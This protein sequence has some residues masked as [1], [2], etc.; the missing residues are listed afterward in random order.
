MQM[1]EQHRIQQ[2]YATNPDGSPNFAP[3]HSSNALS[4]SG[5]MGGG[6][7]AAALKESGVLELLS[8]P[9]GRAAIGAL[10]GRV[11]SARQKT[12]SDIQ[13]WD[14]EKKSV[15]F[16]S[17]IEH[18]LITDMTTTAT[19]PLASIM[20]FI[21]LPDHDIE[22]LMSFMLVAADK[23]GKL[24]REF[25]ASTAAGGGLGPTDQG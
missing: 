22:Q 21:A 2:Q 7:S 23:D 12:E 16:N 9:D 6:A 8:K 10:A 1:R 13:S 4:T 14:D 18:P 24:M 25:N 19:D 3:N 17:F 20:K 11:Q 15:F 5:A